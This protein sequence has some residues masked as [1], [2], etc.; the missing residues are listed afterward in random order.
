MT[1]TMPRAERILAALT[2]GETDEAL[3]R[4]AAEIA[5]SVKAEP[6]NA[7]S[8][9][10][11][12]GIAV[13]V[14][15]GLLGVHVRVLDGTAPERPA[16]FERQRSL[17]AESGGTFVEITG[18]DAPTALLEFAAAEN[19]TQIVVA[20]VGGHT[21]RAYAHRLF[22]TEV[23]RRA[24]D[25]D[26]HVVSVSAVHAPGE[27][28]RLPA[29]PPRR[30]PA[31]VSA[32]RTRWAWLIGTAGMA[33]LVAALSPW[34]DALG[35][36]GTLLFLLLVVA[37]TA[38]LGGLRPTAGASVVGAVAA[39]FFLT[40]P[41]YSLLMTEPV[42]LLAVLVFLA[43]AGIISTL[44]DRL[45]RRGLQVARARAE[46]EALARLAGGSV[47]AGP[48][49]L[50]DLVAQLRRTFEM[51]SV[52]VLE[53]APTGWSVLARAGGPVP[54]HPEDARY[55]A[56]L[57][58][59]AVLT[60]DGRALSPDDTAL[61][62][63]F[64]SQLRLAQEHNRLEGQATRA[65]E[66]A[67]VD[68]LRAALLDAVSHDLRT[69]LAGIK[70]AV[71]SLLTPEA[72]WGEQSVH[73]FHTTIDRETDRLTGL[74]ENLLDLSRLRAGTL[75]LVLRDADLEKVLC[76]AVDTLADGGAPVDLDLPD[77]LPPVRA[78]AGLLERALA[79]VL[80]NARAVTPAGALVTVQAGSV[81]D[82]VDVCVVDAGP[83]VP[84]ERRDQVFQPFQRFDDA[85]GGGRRGLGLGLAIARGFTEA[86][87]GRLAVRDAPEGG[88]MFVFSLVPAAVDAE[89]AGVVAGGGH[90]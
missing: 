69:P 29:V 41:R 49:T 38:R 44:I 53:P 5:R 3:L 77:R 65:A 86:M 70:A 59:G 63:P 40:S 35:L 30:G 48:H 80:A 55:S 57:D 17:L 8:E 37:F 19:V 28:S 21:R 60:L 22:L 14:G 45:A 1:G 25:V 58:Q 83:G 85:P 12:A 6:E 11:E 75:P 27:P 72:E 26:V 68:A 24:Q 7:E 15:G 47:M 4:R 33:G 84:P 43:V 16:S 87:G 90:G 76:R 81:G 67:E 39:D 42:E 74:V 18:V 52:A 56:P 73:R 20:R 31:T 13:R 62:G 78:D 64:V 88:A 32:R 79:N 36:P 89:A 71:T 82:R 23:I 34:H 66:L 10:P 9:N 61:L 50:P 54:E 2:G 51:D 46:A